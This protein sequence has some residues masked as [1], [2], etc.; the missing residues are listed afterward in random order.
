[1]IS[2]KRI[3]IALT[4]LFILGCDKV[5][6]TSVQQQKPSANV[7]SGSSNSITCSPVLNGS[8]QQIS[9]MTASNPTLN[10]NCN[11]VG[12]NYS[13]LVTNASGSAV[14]VNGLQGADSNPDFYA[15]GS[16]V[17]KI[18][19]TASLANYTS[20]VSS[21]LQVTVSVPAATAINCTVTANG[22]T[23]PVN[24]TAGSGV[25]PL[26]AANCNPANNAYVWTVV[27]SGNPVVVAGLSG[28][29]STPGFD[30][31]N[32]GA[33]NL[34]LLASQNGYASYQSAQPLV[35]NVNAPATVAKV[36]Q[37]NVSVQNNQVDILLVV[38]DSNSMLKHNQK[39][40]SKLQ[41]F[42]NNLS[43]SGLDWQ[44][45]VT[46]TR[47]LPVSGNS[48]L[49]WGASVFWNGNPNTP[50]YILKNGTT[51]A[52]Q[53]FANTI[54]S[55]GA[56]WA[57]TEDERPLKAAWWSFWNGDPRLSNASGCYRQN[58]SLALLFI[59]NEDE[60]SIGGDKSQQYYANEYF[61]LNSD[62]TPQGLLSQVTS[63]FGA[64]KKFIANAIVV[65]PG[66]NACMALDDATGSK[67]HF[68]VVNSQIAS[69]TGGYVGSICDADYSQSLK[70]FQDSIVKTAKS[71]VLDCPPISIQSVTV[72][73]TMAFTY[74]LAGKV[75]TFNP[76]IPAGKNIIINY[77][78]AQ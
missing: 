11:P 5:N 39:L 37:S 57:G 62:D 30:Q 15:L 10:A 41:G 38:D 23:N 52:D 3:I 13:W 54:N 42:V 9:V 4:F 74:S 43:T 22:Q 78:C 16:G 76:E 36:F 50:G 35:I 46:T 48:N 55:I 72:T 53:I 12:V 65:R 45:C 75:V 29:S 70:Y 69:L 18:V 56:G 17:Y 19:L 64:N 77:T 7:T 63:I 68:G 47:A 27:K 28:A 25:N 2:Q 6:F 44:M 49:Y 59:S 67:S 24:V 8:Q 66:D 21:P 33:Y 26:I 32:P 14:T 58:A 40:A 31:L 1:M 61:A 73:P 34:S 71:V 60:R 20:F 51:G